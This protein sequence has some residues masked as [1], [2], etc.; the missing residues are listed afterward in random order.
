LLKIHKKSAKG[1]SIAVKNTPIIIFNLL[2][3]VGFNRTD[4]KTISAGIAKSTDAA[5]SFIGLS[6]I[7]RPFTSPCVF[8]GTYNSK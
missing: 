1:L 7:F 2:F 4:K 8:W 5:K 6:N 3:I